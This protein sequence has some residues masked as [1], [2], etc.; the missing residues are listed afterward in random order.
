MQAGT[1][2]QKTQNE[3]NKLQSAICN[4]EKNRAK[5]SNNNRLKIG[6]GHAICLSWYSTQ[7]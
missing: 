4:P 6:T 2:L 3:A 1:P 7:Q 5:T